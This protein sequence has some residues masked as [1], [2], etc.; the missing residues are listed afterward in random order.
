MGSSR[1]SGVSQQRVNGN[2]GARMECFSKKGA[3]MLQASAGVAMCC[4]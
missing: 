1:F 3:L 2:E 4:A